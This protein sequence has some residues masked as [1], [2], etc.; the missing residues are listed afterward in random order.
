MVETLVKSG[1]NA[2]AAV[3]VSSCVKA[4]N[5]MLNLMTIVTHM[6]VCSNITMHTY[7]YLSRI[8][9]LLCIL[10]LNMDMLQ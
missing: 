3:I 2:G 6:Y 5:C 10:L 1:A 4:V 9:G 8:N 7:V